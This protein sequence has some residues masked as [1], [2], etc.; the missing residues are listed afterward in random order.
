M[1][2]QF[3][4]NH[5]GKE[6]IFL[7]NTTNLLLVPTGVLVGYHITMDQNLV[8]FDSMPT[9]GKR[10]FDPSVYSTPVM[11]WVDT[12]PKGHYVVSLDDREI[13][14]LAAVASTSPAK[15]CT[16]QVP[17]II[18]LGQVP[19]TTKTVVKKEIPHWPHICPRCKGEAAI[20]F[21]TIDCR[22]GCK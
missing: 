22:F 7:P 21:S 10:G 6:V 17:A 4:K 2:C 1:P 3:A 15:G 12:I 5:P 8:A 11:F 13:A 18:A 20:L 16:L 9:R 19:L 14:C